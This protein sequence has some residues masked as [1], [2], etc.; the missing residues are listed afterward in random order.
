MTRISRKDVAAF[1]LEEAADPQFRRR[2][3]NLTY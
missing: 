2:I 1:L 3:V